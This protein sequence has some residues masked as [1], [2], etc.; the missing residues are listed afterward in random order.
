VI[1]G[2]LRTRQLGYRMELR[3]ITETRL[4]SLDRRTAESAREIS[5]GDGQAYFD[6]VRNPVQAGSN[7]AARIRLEREASR[8]A[9]L[10]HMGLAEST[11]APP[12]ACAPGLLSD[13]PSEAANQ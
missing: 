13:S 2:D 5:P 9:V 6:V 3:E 11:G 12:V 7:E 4:T 10:Q 8:L 1:A